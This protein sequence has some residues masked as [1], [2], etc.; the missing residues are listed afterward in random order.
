M[1]SLSATKN[2]ILRVKKGKKEPV[3][4]NHSPSWQK[5]LSFKFAAVYHQLHLIGLFSIRQLPSLVGDHFVGKR[6]IITGLQLWFTIFMPFVKGDKKARLHK[7]CISTIGLALAT[8]MVTLTQMFVC[9]PG[10]HF[11]V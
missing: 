6:S 4:F 11:C 3:R 1:K 5:H 8:R 9:T 2:N 7:T 10:K